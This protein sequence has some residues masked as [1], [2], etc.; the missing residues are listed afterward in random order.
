MA[1]PVARLPH[2]VQLVVPVPAEVVHAHISSG[3]SL[4]VQSQHRQRLYILLVHLRKGLEEDLEIVHCA[5]GHRFDWNHDL[6]LHF[7]DRAARLLSHKRL[8]LAPVPQMEAIRDDGV[9]I[10]GHAANVGFRAAHDAHAHVGVLARAAPWVHAQHRQR[11]HVAHVAVKF[12]DAFEQK[13]DVPSRRGLVCLEVDHVQHHQRELCTIRDA[14]REL[15]AW[16]ILAATRR[17]APVQHVLCRGSRPRSESIADANLVR[18]KANL[19]QQPGNQLLHHLGVFNRNGLRL[20]VRG[21]LEALANVFVADRVR[22]D[23]ILV[24]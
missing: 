1:Q 12:L 10:S 18:Q 4:S 2:L 16:V 6:R 13:D 20:V 24:V 9:R 11:S 3:K 14:N 21:V 5:V 22:I 23:H 19:R 17:R 15:Q 8:Q 7:E